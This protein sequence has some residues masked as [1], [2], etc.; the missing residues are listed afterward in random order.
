MKTDFPEVVLKTL[1]VMMILTD[2][3][4]LTVTMTPTEVPK[5]LI[6]LQNQTQAAYS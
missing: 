5:V 3:I 6:I 4:T 1:M 2:Q